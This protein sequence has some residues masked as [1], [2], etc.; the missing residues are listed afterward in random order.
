M[1]TERDP[2]NHWTGGSEN[3]NDVTLQGQDKCGYKSMHNK[4]P[5]EK[6]EF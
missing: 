3:Y 2:S 6:A 4:A 5:K 1:T